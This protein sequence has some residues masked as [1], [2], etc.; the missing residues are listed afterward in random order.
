MVSEEG[1]AAGEALGEVTVGL[2][3]EGEEISGGLLR[4]DVNT[5]GPR[6]ST[7]WNPP[8]S[9]NSLRFSASMLVLG[10]PALAEK[11]GSLE[12]SGVLE[13]ATVGSCCCSRRNSLICSVV[14]SV[15]AASTRPD[16]SA[17]QQVISNK[18]GITGFML[19]V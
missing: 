14:V 2:P 17:K 19:L 4:P 9:C 15:A 1:V 5:D 12:V 10:V 3:G 11:R 8:P 6:V 13:T 16:K 7:G 18:Q